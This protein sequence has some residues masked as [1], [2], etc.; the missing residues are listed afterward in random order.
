[1]QPADDTLPLHAGQRLL[2]RRKAKGLTTEQLAALMTE[3]GAKVSRAAISNWE[4]G[5]NGIVSNKLPV[6]ARLLD[7]SESYLLSGFLTAPY[8]IKTSSIRILNSYFLTFFDF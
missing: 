7:C 2:Q 4:R 3:A 6:L 8:W 1:M 5:T